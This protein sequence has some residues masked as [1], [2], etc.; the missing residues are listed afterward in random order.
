MTLSNKTAFAVAIACSCLQA[1]HSTTPVVLVNGYH[2]DCSRSSPT[3]D[4]GQL[5]SLLQNDSLGIAIGY[6]NNCDFPDYSIDQLGQ[7]FGQFLG[8]L[9]TLGSGPV[10]V[11]AHSMGGLIVRSYLAGLNLQANTVTPPLNPGIRKLILIGTPNFGTA[12]SNPLAIAQ[13]VPEMQYATQFIWDLATWNQWGDDLRGI[14]TVAIAGNADAGASDG[15]V[16]ISSASVGFA[17]SDGDQRTRVI[18]YCH[19]NSDLADWATSCTGQGGIAYIDSPSHPSYQIIRSFLDGSNAWQSVGLSASQ[20]WSFGGLMLDVVDQNDQGVSVTNASFAAFPLQL[21]SAG[22]WYRDG[23]S[24]TASLGFDIQ[25]QHYSTA[26]VPVRSGAFEV[27]RPKDGPVIYPTGITSSAGFAP[28]AHSV[29]PGSL[30]SIYGRNLASSSA[31]ARYP[32][33]VQLADATVTIAGQNALLNYASDGQINALVP[34][35]APGFYT[36]VLNNSQG[37]DSSDF[38]V[39]AAVPTLFAEAGG[40]AAAEHSNGTLVSPS[41]P[42]VIGE[43]ISLWGTGLGST[44]VQN[45]LNVAIATPSVFIDGQSAIV[46]FAGRATGYQ[47]LDQINV[48]IP[49]GIRR[50]VSVPLVMTSGSRSSNQVFLAV[51]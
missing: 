48:Q 24:G 50:G 26:N 19:T 20:A 17:S 22:V 43:Y 16:T 21:G 9:Q 12:W 3:D 27:I 7:A 11:I 5:M 14:D 45:G 8:Q 1:Q 47:G 39:E 44:T 25:G 42:A 40:I 35:L 38:M 51:N 34:D 36:L 6:S 10:D 33:P 13:Q 15:V 46:T 37:S 28:G 31:S 30:I 2:L 4:F 41:N 23:I 49:T 18:P 29:A 32:W